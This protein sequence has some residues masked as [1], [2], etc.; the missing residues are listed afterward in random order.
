MGITPFLTL[1]KEV[2]AHMVQV[3]QLTLH[4]VAN[5]EMY[6]FLT[7][8]FLGIATL[9]DQAYRRNLI[10]DVYMDQAGYNCESILEPLPLKVKASASESGHLLV[11]DDKPKE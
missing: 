6:L 10:D 1:M 9:R 2:V 4:D 8:C 3:S 7:S 5:F 11:T